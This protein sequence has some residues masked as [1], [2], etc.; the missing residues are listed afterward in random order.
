M[1]TYIGLA[2]TVYKRLARIVYIQYIYGIFGRV[3]TKYMVLIYGVFGTGKSPNKRSYTV[4]YIHGTGQPYVYIQ[5][6]KAVCFS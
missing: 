4:K 2:R 1:T 6:V 3:I 5:Y